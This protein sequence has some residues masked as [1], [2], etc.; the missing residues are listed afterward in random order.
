MPWPRG[1]RFPGVG[2]QWASSPIPL[3]L[4][5]PTPVS[6]REVCCPPAMSGPDL[7]LSVSDSI[8]VRKPRYVRRE[9]PLDRDVGPTTVSS[10]EARVSNV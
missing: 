10:V 6:P 8:S 2:A 3:G 7:T 4:P 1:S 5:T 9:R